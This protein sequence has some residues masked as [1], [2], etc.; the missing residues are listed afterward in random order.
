MLTSLFLSSSSRDRSTHA[1]I[2][3]SNCSIRSNSSNSSDNSRRRSRNNN[4]RTVLL[5]YFAVKRL[6]FEFS[7]LKVVSKNIKKGT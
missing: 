6:N 5:S 2:R 4:R 1:S 3:S 7:K